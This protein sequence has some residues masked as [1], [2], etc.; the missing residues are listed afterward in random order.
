[1]TA[2]SIPAPLIAACS[3]IRLARP[4]DSVAGAQPSYVASPAST[5]EASAVMRAASSLSLAVLPRGAGTRLEWGAP[6]SR[7]DLVIETTRMDQVLEHAA[8]DLVARVQAGASVRH[9]ATVLRG[10]GQQLAPASRPAKW[11]R[12]AGYWPPA[13]PAPGGCATGRPVTC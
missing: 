5:Q 1:L 8:G 12:S 7:C 13:W 2:D 9:L 6:P 10:A 3:G 11:A 4:A